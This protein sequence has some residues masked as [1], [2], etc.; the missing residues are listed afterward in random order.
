MGTLGDFLYPFF[1]F[2]FASLILSHVLCLLSERL[3][4]INYSFQRRFLAAKIN[5]KVIFLSCRN[6][7]S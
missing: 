6:E 2:N 4:T 1:S 5:L 7:P 3:A